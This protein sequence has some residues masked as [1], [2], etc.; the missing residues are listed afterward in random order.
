MAD[1][2]VDKRPIDSVSPDTSPSSVTPVVKRVQ[3]N[4]PESSVAPVV[5]ETTSGFSLKPFELGPDEKSEPW[6]TD[7]FVRINVCMAS[8]VSQVIAHLDKK[9]NELNQATTCAVNYAQKTAES[10][11]EQCSDLVSSVQALEKKCVENQVVIQ[12]LEREN[13]DLKDRLV[14][15]ESQSRRDNLLFCGFAETAG[16][17]SSDCE[18][19][20]RGL[21]KRMGLN[22]NLRIARCHRKGT[23]FPGRQRAIIVKFE[24]FEDRQK[25]WFSR[26]NLHGSNKFIN[27]DFPIEIENRRKKLYPILKAARKFEHYKGKVNIVFDKLYVNNMVYRVETLHTLPADINPRNLCERYDDNSFC[28]FGE[29]SPLSNFHQCSFRYDGVDYTSSEVAF[30]HAK[31]LHFKDEIKATAILKARSPAEAKELG[32]NL[33]NFDRVNWANACEGYMKSILECKFHQN[34]ELRS[35][36]EKTGSRLIIECNPKDNYWGSGV[37]VWDQ[38]CLDKEKRRGQNRLGNLLMSVRERLL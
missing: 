3:V 29:Y 34:Q 5:M 8:V 23:S 14:Y 9:I 12:K 38:E 33:R 6:M 36:L 13:F 7:L 35:H 22:E 18:R 24:F 30:Q 4:I 27:E 37:A 11:I 2:T 31:A 10:A 28:F 25:V 32:K 16:E 15:I 17:T 19:K 21:F 1:K 20:V 26:K